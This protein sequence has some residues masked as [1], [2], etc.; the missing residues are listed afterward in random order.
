[1]LNTTFDVET[2]TSES[3]YL[4]KDLT[5]NE[6]RKVSKT[7]TVYGPN[8]TNIPVSG[9]QNERAPP[10]VSTD[11]D[12]GTT[13]TV[14]DLFLLSRPESPYSRPKV[15]SLLDRVCSGVGRRTVPLLI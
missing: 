12:L 14:P 15:P 3:P 13:V 6:R 9:F 1:M 5:T 4:T 2:Q 7:K 10:R 11:H 8:S